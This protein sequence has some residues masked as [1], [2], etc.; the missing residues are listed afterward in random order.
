MIRFTDLAYCAVTYA[1]T[2]S[3]SG[4]ATRLLV[5]YILAMHASCGARLVSEVEQVGR[6]PVNQI[7]D[8]EWCGHEELRFMRN[9]IGRSLNNAAKRCNSPWIDT[10]DLTFGVLCEEGSSGS[11]YL[12]QGGITRGELEHVYAR[13]LAVHSVD[14]V[15]Q[16]PGLLHRVCHV[17]KANSGRASEIIIGNREAVRT[18]DAG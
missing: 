10:A 1:T 3:M 11:Q 13:D 8:Q 16:R 18:Q 9:V 14:I 5:Q 12:L 7:P 15:P 4:D 17:F 2:R 6:L